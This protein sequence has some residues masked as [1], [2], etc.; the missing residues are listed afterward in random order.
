MLGSD[1]GTTSIGPSK[2]ARVAISSPTSASVSASSRYMPLRRCNTLS[3]RAM[4]SCRRAWMALKTT[5]PCSSLASV[6]PTG[7]LGLLSAMSS[8][9]VRTTPCPASTKKP[10]SWYSTA[11]GGLKGSGIAILRMSSMLRP[12]SIS[13]TCVGWMLRDCPPREPPLSLSMV[14]ALLMCALSSR[15]RRAPVAAALR[16]PIMCGKPM[17]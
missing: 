10:R 16:P 11:E 4:A 9:V 6:V 1:T 17:G 12:P 13:S 2:S 15:A 14:G 3:M 7:A 8:S 5:M